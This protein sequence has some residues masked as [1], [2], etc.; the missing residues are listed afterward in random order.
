[1]SSDVRV[2]QQMSH[3]SYV[4]VMNKRK[5]TFC[6]E[7]FGDQKFFF[8]I[9][10]IFEKSKGSHWPKNRPHQKIELWL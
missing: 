4:I 9:S 1:M 8:Q 6:A 3:L 5:N 7:K 10:K 2:L